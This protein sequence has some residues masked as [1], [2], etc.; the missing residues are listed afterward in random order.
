[1]RRLLALA[2]VPLLAAG[3][4]VGK[5]ASE[6]PP[7]TATAAATTTAAAPAT[8][9][10]VVYFLRDGK[11]APVRVEVPETRAVATAAL[12]A[13]LAGPPKGYETA[14]PAGGRLLTL[15]ID[16]GVATAK[17]SD[18]LGSLDAAGEAQLVYTLTRFGTVTGV[19]T[20]PR[21]LVGG[22]GMPLTEP[23][24][25]ADFEAETP[26]ILIESPLPGDEVASPLRVTGT[27]N[28]FEATFQ[29]ELRG[30]GETLVH[31][32]VTA[33]S[34]TG[35]RGTFSAELPFSAGG[36]ATIVAWEDNMGEGPPVLHRVEVPVS[37]R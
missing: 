1:M 6:R 13:L 7:T 26:A 24:T 20:L 32:T 27:A 18:E 37:L 8:S 12:H 10:A 16:A 30:D 33:T 3:C 31:R 11:V 22:D 14:L 29:L 15:S 9:T 5:E 19:R 17:L 36:A 35:E 34:G 28:A 21:P 23:A 25:R 2:A 4:G